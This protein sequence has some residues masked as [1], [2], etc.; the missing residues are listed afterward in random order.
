MRKAVRTTRSRNQHFVPLHDCL[1]WEI[2]MYICSRAE[3]SLKTR[4]P[5]LIS[6]AVL[7][8]GCT[9]TNTAC[10]GRTAID[11]RD[12]LRIVERRVRSALENNKEF[13]GD[14]RSFSCDKSCKL[15]EDN[16]DFSRI[17]MG[18]SDPSYF[19]VQVTMPKMIKPNYAYT[20]AV[21][22]YRCGVIS[23]TD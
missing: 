20:E 23:E 16:L 18:A 6:C 14:P 9:S 7:L 3:G 4:L 19:T 2:I 22:L 13:A 15:V 8:S 1:A 12:A 5:T 11:N 10:D 21:Y 17:I